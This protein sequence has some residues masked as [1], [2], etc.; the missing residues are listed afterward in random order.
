MPTKTQVLYQ[1]GDVL[2]ESATAPEKATTIPPTARG[3]ILE[4]SATTRHAH[5]I[6]VAKHSKLLKDA[7]GTLYVV[8]K[9]AFTVSHEEH[10]PITIPAGTYRLRGVR[11]YDHF[12]EEA[13]RVID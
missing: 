10:K 4:E 3:H 1:Q 12:E 2:I 8:A 13:R 6:A 11:E 9:R 5:V 7:T